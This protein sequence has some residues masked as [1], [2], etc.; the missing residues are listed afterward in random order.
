MAFPLAGLFTGIGAVVGGLFKFKG[1]QAEVI[2]SAIQV[3]GDV[4]ASNAQ[5]EQAVAS[6]IAA[7]AGSESVLARIWRPM[8]MVTFAGIII[9]YWF[10]YAPPNIDGP[11]SPMMQEIFGILKIGVGGYIGGRTIE[12]IVSNIGLSSALKKFVEKKIV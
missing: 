11:L 10:G 6:I 7:E 4:S 12:K 9:S 2:Q 1:R 8:L 3:L 5:R